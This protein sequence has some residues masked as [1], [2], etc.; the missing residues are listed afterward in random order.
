MAAPTSATGTMAGAVSR[1]LS[2]AGARSGTRALRRVALARPV[3][4]SADRFIPVR[5]HAALRVQLQRAVET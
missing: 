1:A 2:R 4:R 3:L 5:A